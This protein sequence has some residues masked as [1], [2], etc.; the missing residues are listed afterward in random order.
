M[1]EE[2]SAARNGWL[3][4][5]F[6]RDLLAAWPGVSDIEA[7]RGTPGSADIDADFVAKFESR[8]LLVEAKSQTPQTTHRLQQLVEQL[9]AAGTAYQQHHG[10]QHQPRLVLAFPGVLLPQR[11]AK[12]QDAGVE[13]WDGER[14]QRMARRVGVTTPAFLA[15][16]EEE[17]PAERE[18]ADELRRRLIAIPKG[19]GGASAFEQFAEDV[20]NLLFVPPLNTVIPQSSNENGVNRRDLV[21]P[22]YAP[23]DTFWGFLRLHYRGDFIVAEAKNYSAPIKKEQVLQLANYLSHHGTGLVGM[24]LTRIGLAQDARW[25]SREQWLLYN[26][27]IIGLGDDDYHQ[28]LLTHRAGGDPAEL[29][30][31]R[32]ED[33][34]LRI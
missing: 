3:F 14:L 1:M 26:K 6:M 17:R 5:Q 9:R 18:P 20:L 15:V 24:L 8:P 2:R 23:A 4:I 25:T 13:I 28:M 34:R 29:V 22:N 30:R 12:V 31:Q 19:K 7:E 11:H 10:P 16:P 27:L 32:I 33:F 21:L